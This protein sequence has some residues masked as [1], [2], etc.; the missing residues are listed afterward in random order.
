MIQAALRSRA[1]KLGRLPELLA[2]SFELFLLCSTLF[3]N[4]LR[5]LLGFASATT[6]LLKMARQ[7]QEKVKLS[8]A[9]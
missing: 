7:L 9:T 2:L 1:G 6:N 5:N 3:T 4:Y 8:Y